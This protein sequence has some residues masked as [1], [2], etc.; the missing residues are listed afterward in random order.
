MN[1]NLITPSRLT[2]AACAAVAA[3][4][5][6]TAAIAIATESTLELVLVPSATVR[7]GSA[8]AHPSATRGK[9]DGVAHV[10][11]IFGAS[12]DQ[13]MASAI[14]ESEPSK[15]SFPDGYPGDE[16]MYFISGNVTLTDHAGKVTKVGP[17]E[18]LFMPKGWRGTWTSTAYRKYFVYYDQ[19]AAK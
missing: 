3:G 12:S 1:L 7:D 5:L 17:G 9:E 10:M 16:F 11:R 18:A 13:R 2:K 19:A 14:F 15:L 6:A 8:F 4:V